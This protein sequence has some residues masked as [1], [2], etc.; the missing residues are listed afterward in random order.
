MTLKWSSRITYGHPNSTFEYPKNEGVYIIAKK[1]D[2]KLKARYVGQGKI[3]DRMKIHE[4]KSEPNDCLRKTMSNLDDIEVY[5]AL[6]PHQTDRENAEFT[7]FDLYGGLPKL[8][9]DVTPLGNFD[10][11]IKGPFLNEISFD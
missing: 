6:V 9:N 2:G 5:Y 8:C 7:L 10:Y 4:G 3:Y 1:I 11:T